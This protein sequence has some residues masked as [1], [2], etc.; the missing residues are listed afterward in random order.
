MAL[1][2]SPWD[3]EL[4]IDTLQLGRTGIQPCSR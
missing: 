2:L 3:Q 1:Q 4:W